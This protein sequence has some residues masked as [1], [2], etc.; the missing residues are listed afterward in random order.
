VLTDTVT[1]VAAGPVTD[2]VLRGL[3]VN[4]VLPAGVVGASQIGR[5]REQLGNNVVDLLEDGLGQ[6]TGSNSGIAGLVGGEALLPA[7]GKLA[8]ETAGELST[9]GLELGGV[10]LEEL[11]PGLFLGGTLGGVLGVEVIDLLRDDEA[12]VGVEAE[13]LLDTLAVIGL[14]GVTVDTAGALELGTETNGGGQADHGGLVLDGLGLL[15]GGL[16]GLEV[17]V[18]VLDPDGVPAVGLEALGD[19]LSESALG[20]TVYREER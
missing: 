15:D 2:T 1:E 16:N 7:L 13:A 12:L 4:G 18:T 3:E 9:L 11:V 5:A 14:E 10:L 17:V 6:L 20:V 8:G 19:I